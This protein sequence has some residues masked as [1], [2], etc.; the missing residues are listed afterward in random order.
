MRRHEAFNKTI[1]NCFIAEWCADG[2]R[3]RR[4]GSASKADCLQY[5]LLSSAPIKETTIML[6]KLSF[7]FHSYIFL[8]IGSID[9]QKLICYNEQVKFN[10][11]HKVS[12]IPFGLG[13]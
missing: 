7:L 8:K 2:Y 13:W 9:F 6:R 1:V 5:A 4:L 11:S 12:A 3:S 10:N